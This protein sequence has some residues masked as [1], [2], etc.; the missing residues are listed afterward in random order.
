MC[1]TLEYNS[2]DQTMIL[3]KQW[4]IMD[5]F[6]IRWLIQCLKH[7]PIASVLPQTA[8]ML[9]MILFHRIT[10]GFVYET[11]KKEVC[12]LQLYRQLRSFDY[13]LKLFILKLLPNFMTK[14]L[15]EFHFLKFGVILESDYFGRNYTKQ[16]YMNYT[17]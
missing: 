7:Y 17:R 4:I 13:I 8:S 1:I 11:E 9:S 5:T 14:L 2:I 12:K 3:W 10:F 16:N 6:L 15:F